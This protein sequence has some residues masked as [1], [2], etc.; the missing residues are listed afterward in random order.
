MLEGLVSGLD[1]HSA[2]SVVSYRLSLVL[3]PACRAQ[4]GYPDGL[5]GQGAIL[6]A[7]H[8]AWGYLLALSP[9]VTTSLVT[10]RATFSLLHPGTRIESV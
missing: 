7:S 5:E 6:K 3:M 4:A 1:R 9:F 10:G 8:S 2:T